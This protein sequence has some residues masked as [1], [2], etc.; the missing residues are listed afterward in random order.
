MMTD[1]IDA[2]DCDDGGGNRD[3]VIVMIHCG[4]KNWSHRRRA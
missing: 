4:C 1:G 3:V 2:D